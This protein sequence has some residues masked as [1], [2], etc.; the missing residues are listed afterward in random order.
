[1]VGMLKTG[2]LIQFSEMITLLNVDM[3]PGTFFFDEIADF[4]DIA[5]I[6]SLAKRR[7]GRHDDSGAYTILWKD[8]LVVSCKKYFQQIT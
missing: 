6:I 3:T 8:R 5:I 2:D 7:D 4:G 1:M